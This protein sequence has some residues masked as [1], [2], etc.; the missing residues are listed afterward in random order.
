MQSLSQA[1]KHVG[2]V[3]KLYPNWAE[4]ITRLALRSEAFRTMCEDYGMAVEALELLEHRNLPQDAHKMQEYRALV[5][6]LENEL[7]SELLAAGAA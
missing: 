3:R 2:R 7:K 6:E 4:E 1:A 5:H